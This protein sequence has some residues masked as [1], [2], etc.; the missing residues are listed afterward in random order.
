MKTIF[1]AR[2]V[3]LCDSLSM[4]KISTRT[5]PPGYALKKWLRTAPPLQ[6]QCHRSKQVCKLAPGEDTLVSALNADS[7][8]PREHR[9]TAKAPFMQ[10]LA[11]G[12]RGGDSAV[13]RFPRAWR[14][15][16]GKKAVRVFLPLCIDLGE[17]FQFDWN[18]EGIV[19]A[20]DIPHF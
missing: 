11:Q 8:R 10:I 14:E 7:H 12:P 18:E 9:R 5:G 17:A 1:R 19:V 3:R 20:G 4:R 6:T 16:A 15:N 13:G 2:R